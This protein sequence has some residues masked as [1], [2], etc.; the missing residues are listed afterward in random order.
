[1]I[2]LIVS[3]AVTFFV[4][5]FSLLFVVPTLFIASCS[6]TFIFIWVFVGYVILRK[7]NERGASTKP[8]TRIGGRLQS[9]GAA[10]NGNGAE[11]RYAAGPGSSGDGGPV[12]GVHGTV[13]WER[14][15]A[16]GV[17]PSP[18]VL[19][20]DNA[21]EVLKA[22]STDRVCGRQLLMND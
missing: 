6:A 8:S 14:R 19:E 11:E 12:N 15:W 4:V 17:K 9:D 5:G 22:V 3:L 20:T 10:T 18:V 13:E 1:L 7:F 21:Y 16:D 2:G